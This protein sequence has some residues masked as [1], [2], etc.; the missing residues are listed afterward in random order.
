MMKLFNKN[1]LDELQLVKRGNIFKHGLFVM[2][3]L[4]LLKT[5]LENYNIFIL[6]EKWGNLVII[7]FTIALCSIE[8]I[9]YDIYPLSEKRQ[10][11][12]IY[13]VGLFGFVSIVISIFDMVNENI[14]FILEKQ[15]SDSAIGIIFGCIFISI[16]IAYIIKT[17]YN[18]R[19]EENE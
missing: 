9:C 12:M 16:F 10:K 1:N 4:L 5:L 13:F 17:I 2:G 3:G 18:E 8:M 15:L 14:A 7:L 19:H 6:N 11:F